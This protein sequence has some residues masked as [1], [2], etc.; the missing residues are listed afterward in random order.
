MKYLTQILNKNVIGV[1]GQVVG[2]VLDAVAVMGGRLPEVKAILIRAGKSE[3]CIP[4]SQVEFD[5]DPAGPNGSGQIQSDIRLLSPL[6]DI[7]PFRPKDEDLRLRQDM[8]DKQIVDVHDYRVVRVSDVRLAQC[9]NEYCVV[10]VDASL[11]ATIRRMGSP[12][13][14]PVEALA[15]LIRKPLRS[16]LIAWDDVQTLEPG[17]AG[18]RIRLRVSHDKIARLHP[19]DIADIVEQ[20]SPQ[21][22]AEVIDSLDT[23]TV[24][25]AMAEVEPDVQKQIMEQLSEEQAS[26]ILEQ[27][28][29][30][31]AAD[32]L[33]LLSNSKSED[34]IEGMEPEEAEAVERLMAYHEDTAGGLMTTEFVA[35]HD[36]LT[37]EETIE[38]LRELAPRAET[39]YYVYVVDAEERLVG[40]LSLRD[41]VISPPPTCVKD[42]MVRNVIHVYE[43]DHADE[44]AQIIGRYNLFAVP[45]VNDSEQ[46][47]GIV[48][49]D[50]TLERLLPPDRRRRLPSPALQDQD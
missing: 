8:L 42:I 28:E 44:V 31:D 48:T 34:L 38:R 24:A 26:D 1:D 50:D 11:R 17:T 27:M 4:Y 21:D 37:C 9:G 5:D 13:S 40:V 46:L 30:D 41:L 6:S 16:N 33:D 3:I 32:V 39:I 36:N 15:K 35:I 7:V 29:P 47:L 23:E 2:R 18:G 14:K 49:V 22:R 12:I 19:A 43:E 10:G 20:L 45:V 25:D